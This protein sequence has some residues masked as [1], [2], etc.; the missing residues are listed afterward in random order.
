MWKYQQITHDI[1]KTFDSENS[2]LSLK[3]VG[4]ADIN[5]A[6]KFIVKDIIMKTDLWGILPVEVLKNWKT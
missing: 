2:W 3:A 5:I 6:E 4:T 1:S